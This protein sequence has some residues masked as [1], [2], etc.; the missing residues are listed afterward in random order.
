MGVIQMD[1][2]ILRELQAASEL[3]VELRRDLTFDAS[4]VI[5]LDP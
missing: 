4:S 5:V 1:C 2:Q 3:L